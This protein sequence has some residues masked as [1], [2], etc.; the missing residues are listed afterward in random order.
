MAVCE[1][2]A[3]IPASI[4][5]PLPRFFYSWVTTFPKAEKTT[6]CKPLQQVDD[7]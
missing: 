6:G 4:R 1:S 5:D 7:V 2:L 3:F